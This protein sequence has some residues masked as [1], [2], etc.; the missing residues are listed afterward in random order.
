MATTKL[1]DKAVLAAKAPS[2]KRV[3][4][5]D[6]QTPGLC[7]RV[8]D[9]GKKVWV[10]RYRTADGRQPR[11]TLGDYSGAH[12]VRWA[13]DE[14]ET[15]RVEIRKGSDPAADRKKAR[16]A[17]KSQAIKT[18][19]DLADAYLLAMERGEWMPRNKRQRTRTIEDERG[20]LRR[21]ARPVIGKLRLEE[22]DRPTVRQ[23]LRNMAARGIG[24]QTNRTHAVIRQAFSYAM[25][26]ERVAFNPAVGFLAVVQQKPRTRTL[27]DEELTAFWNTLERWPNNLRKPAKKGQEQGELVTVS[28]PMRIIL[29]LC[30]LLLQRRGEIAGMTKAELNL[31]QRL[32]LIPGERMKGGLP[33]LVPLPDRAVKLI[34]EALKLAPEGSP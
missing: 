3:E 6:E 17:A 21:H 11:L 14:V 24:T 10:Y 13:R 25:S 1:T 27:T 22:I 5:W 12:G 32:W 9:K 4:L 23:L 19:D 8:S 26:E 31:D 34:K 28:R 7:L 15:L 30:T 18:F 20:I 29:Q 16:V 33:H 2:G